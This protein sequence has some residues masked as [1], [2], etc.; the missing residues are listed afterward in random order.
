MQ[1]RAQWPE[2]TGERMVAALRTAAGKQPFCRFVAIGTKPA[3]AEHWFSKML[4]GGAEVAIAYAAR[5][6]DPPFH[7]R[8]WLKANPSLPYMPDL[9]RAIR[10]EAG[11]ARADPGILAS[12]RALRL[13]LGTA[14]TEQAYLLD[15][16][17]WE[18]IEGEAA[19]EGR[20]V[21]GLDLSTS[22]AKM[23]SVAAYWPV[24][25]R[26]ECIAAFPREPGLAERG[27][28]DGVG[29]LYTKLEHRG[30]LITTGGA[31]VDLTELFR[32]AL[33]R[34]GAPTAIAA[35]RWREA[36]ARDSLKAAG[37]PVCP[38]E[39]RGMGFRDGSSDVEGFRRAVADGKVTPLPSLL[40]T[41]AM[42]ECR[43]AMDP[44]GNLKITKGTE[45]GRRRR[46]KD[47]AAVAAVLSVALGTRRKPRGRGV[48]L[49]AA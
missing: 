39:P 44:A 27:L 11:E 38:M 18:T 6:Q 14:D 24:G 26:L 37:V 8:T 35:D 19:V 33:E 3:S 1:D 10:K 36:E 5:K 23:S 2:N 20:P 28:A 43:L 41:S 9:E 12:F 32:E 17:T 13:N 47:D 45:G 7:K 22:Y 16:S 30:E 15:A 21:W 31:A 48:F 49:G 4:A 46:A 40:L 29:A 25:G 34:F 42:S